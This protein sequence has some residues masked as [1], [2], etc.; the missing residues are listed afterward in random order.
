MHV[1]AVIAVA[2]VV[3]LVIV[4][5]GDVVVRAMEV[6]Q[7]RAIPASIARRRP[8]TA[9]VVMPAGV[10]MPIVFVLRPVMTVIVCSRVVL[11]VAAINVAI[12]VLAVAL[13]LAM[14]IVGR[15]GRAQAESSHSGDQSRN[16]ARVY[17]MCRTHKHLVLES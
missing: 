10:M 16:D 3:V 11:A 15:H 14:A 1:R 8:V 17:S 2:R 13:A 5:V 9:A 7:I 6:M 4:V 12:C